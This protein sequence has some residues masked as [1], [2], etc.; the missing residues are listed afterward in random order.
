VSKPTTEQRKRAIAYHEAG[1]AA[2]AVYFEQLM[3]LQLIGVEIEM[4]R[5]DR[6]SVDSLEY[7][8]RIAENNEQCEA[9]IV[10]LLAGDVAEKIAGV[11]LI[12]KFE[13]TCDY[14]QIS[15]IIAKPPL[16]PCVERDSLLENLRTRTQTLLGESERWDGVERLAI[17]LINATRVTGKRACELLGPCWRRNP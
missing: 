5:V 8:T 2:F 4:G 13:E 6:T 7:L 11:C 14:H 10:F 9:E 15:S 16:V 12:P 1:H 3:G 17:E